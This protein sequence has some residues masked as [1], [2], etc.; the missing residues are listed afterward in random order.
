M[1]SIHEFN[2]ANVQANVRLTAASLVGNVAQ[3][4]SGLILALSA[5]PNATDA[6]NPRGDVAA[7]FH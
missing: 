7:V 2:K 6:L 3:R 4:R 1:S 5:T